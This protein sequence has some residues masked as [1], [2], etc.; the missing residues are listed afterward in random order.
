[1]LKKTLAITLTLV[2]LLTLAPLAAFADDPLF[3]N[4]TAVYDNGIITVNL[5]V[6][7]AAPTTYSVMATTGQTRAEFIFAPVWM[8]QITW[9]SGDQTFSFPISDNV[10]PGQTVRIFIGPPAQEAVLDVFIPLPTP[11][12]Q[13]VELLDADTPFE[14]PL[15]TQIG[16]TSLDDFKANLIAFFEGYVAEIAKDVDGFSFEVYQK[17]TFEMGEYGYENQCERFF[18]KDLDSGDEY[19]LKHTFEIVAV[20]DPVLEQAL[21]ESVLAFSELWVNLFLAAEYGLILTEELEQYSQ[22]SLEAA[23][24]Y[25]LEV[26]EGPIDET[27]RI[28]WSGIDEIPSP[29]A[30][31]LYADFLTWYINI[32]DTAC[33][34]AYLVLNYAAP[35]FAALDAAIATAKALNPDWYTTGSL[36]ALNAALAA[37]EEAYTTFLISQDEVNVL[38]EAL[39]AAID[40]LECEHSYVA[41]V[42]DP[43][44]IEDG[45]TTN[46]CSRC[47]HTYIDEIVPAFGHTEGWRVRTDGN[48]WELYCGTCE[49]MYKILTIEGATAVFT[50]PAS[51]SFAPVASNSKVQTLIFQVTET[52]SDGSVE[53]VDYEIEIAANNINIDG[54]IDLGVY[55]LFFDI[56]GNGSNIKL[57]EIVMNS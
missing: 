2:M 26:K 5:T 45:F 28:F 23:L 56:K 27:A 35:D 44:C 12:E 25:M 48:V 52:L 39:L 6:S 32:N 16:V 8:D 42:T 1:M 31:Y 7:N 9:G 43:T 4:A 34:T 30:Y 24:K 49:V 50:G 38:T 14:V 51:I 21:T 15:S 18:V 41:T 20:P 57:F 10:S 40:A 17:T 54:S 13:V 3:S 47:E 29:N 46:V 53:V 55:K 11:F 36:A 19:N 22:E 33:A 37:A